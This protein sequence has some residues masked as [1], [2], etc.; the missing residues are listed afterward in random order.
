MFTVKLSD[1]KLFNNLVGVISEFVT[2]ATFTVNKEGLQLVAID[3]ANVAMV[4]MN[5][6]PSAFAEYTVAE[7]NEITL[8]LDKLKLA[9]KRAKPTD[10]ITLSPSDNKLEIMI[11]GTSSKKFSIPLLEKSGSDRRKQD[12]EFKS[13]IGINANG[14]KEFIEDVSIVSD[15]VTFEA[16][17]SKFVIYAG[18]TGSK[19]RIDLASGDDVLA[20]L[21]VKERS[22]SIYSVNYLKK[23][24]KAAAIS[25]VAN[26]SFA[27][28]YPLQMEF[29]ALNQC[30]LSF[31]L[32]PR[33]ENR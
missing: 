2:E 24:A 25:D 4:T 18:D 33:I 13:V 27:T 16:E 21:D 9:L 28:D 14:L 31:I 29:K 5:I 22:R 3:P 7:N 1:P 32:A 10:I 11:T 26:L 8:N 17:P 23:M 6:L 19:V 20:Q 30:V 15:A 12:F